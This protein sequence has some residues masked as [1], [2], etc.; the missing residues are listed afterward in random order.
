MKTDHSIDTLVNALKE[1]AT[2]RQLAEQPKEL[3][4]PTALKPAA[5]QHEYHAGEFLCLPHQHDYVDAIYECILGRPVDD[6]GMHNCLNALQNGMPRIKLLI[7]LCDSE[8]AQSRQLRIHGVDRTRKLRHIEKRFPRVSKYLSNL[9]TWLYGAEERRN[10]SEIQKQINQ[11]LFNKVEALES[12]VVTQQ[13]QS[14]QVNQ[15]EQH[16]AHLKLELQSYKR[17]SLHQLLDKEPIEPLVQA[18]PTE[19]PDI[20]Q[21][22]QQFYLA[23][24]NRFRGTTEQIHVKLK[25]YLDYLPTP[26]DK[27]NYLLDIGCGRGEW[28]SMIRQAGYQE[29]GLDSNPVMIELCNEQG[30][31]VYSTPLHQWLAHAEDN[32]LTGMTG[33]HIAEHLPFPYL[34]S[35]LQE[36]V[37]V[38]KPGGILILETPNPENTSVGSHSFYHDPTHLNPLTP[39]LMQFVAEYIG[40]INVQILR[41]NPLPPDQ[42]FSGDTHESHFLNAKFCSAQDYA[43]IAYKPELPSYQG[44]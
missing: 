19:Q 42:H 28:L 18:S 39:S 5:N 29:I 3:A 2:Q 12:L 6:S 30:L 21:S 23:F 31:N 33:F 4:R 11:T 34:L 22:F 20:D 41:L 7:D 8:E 44:I 1:E 43:L 37:R 14:V 15:L 13:Q 16:I 38:L 10:C 26:N 24:E 9:M 40:L 27:T 25:Q 32:S 36:A 17:Q 35:I